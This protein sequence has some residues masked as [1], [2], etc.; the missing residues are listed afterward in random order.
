MSGIHPFKKKIHFVDVEIE[1]EKN[2]PHSKL[3]II[4]GQNFGKLPHGQELI[5][6]R[7]VHIAYLKW[8]TNKALCIAQAALLNEI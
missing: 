8:I 6:D 4:K 1:A 3:H 2:K 7:G 5:W